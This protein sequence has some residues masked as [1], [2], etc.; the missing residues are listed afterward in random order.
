MN[1]N[2]LTWNK[3]QFLALGNIEKTKTKEKADVFVDHLCE[4]TNAMFISLMFP[5]SLKMIDVTLLH[6]KGRKELKEDYRSV[7]I[8]PTLSKTF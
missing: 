6:K 8:R 7:S 4:S 3:F 1:P 2:S 5:N